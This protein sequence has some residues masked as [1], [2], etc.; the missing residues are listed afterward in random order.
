[1][2]T[3]Q[4][5]LKDFDGPLDLLLTLIGKAKIDIKDIFVSEI[6]DQYLD[7]VRNAGDLDMDDASDFLL[8]AATLLE[9]KSKAMLPVK[10]ETDENEE[11]PETELIRRLEEYKRYRESAESM[12]DFEKA[13]RDVFTKY[14]EEYPLPP[15]EIELTGLT[16]QGLTEAL[17]RIL[18][19]K[20][21]G[22]DN[23]ETNHYA[24]RGIHRDEHTVEGCMTTLLY[25]IRKR[26]KMKFSEVFSE[27]PTREEVL[28]LFLAM[29][30]LMKLGEMYAVQKK[31]C[32]E[33][34]LY[35]GRAPVRNEEEEDLVSMSKRK[36]VRSDE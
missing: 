6:T 9:I 12:K 28:T 5:K 30:E 20:P 29:L 34:M 19:R 15:Q 7:I 22:D 25:D 33:I 18:A 27:V 36:K 16:L 14:P 26:K 3:H 32:E 11:D 31:A 13:S 23:P 1:M 10:Q 35:A 21:V 2:I 24:P 4:F 17:R 8:M